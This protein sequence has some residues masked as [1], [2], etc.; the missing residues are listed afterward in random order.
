MWIRSPLWDGIWILSGA[1]LAAALLCLSTPQLYAILF[2]TVFADVGHSFS[3]VVLAWSHAGYREIMLARKRKYILLPLVIV[4]ATV[5]IGG[6]TTAGFLYYRPDVGFLKQMRGLD[7]TIN[8]PWL[9]VIWVYLV[10]NSYH[11]A[12]QNFGVL[13]LY[14]MRS[15]VGSRAVDKVFSFATTG[16]A[17]AIALPFSFIGWLNAR[18]SVFICTVTA[19]VAVLWMLWHDIGWGWC[20]PR[21]WLIA[22]D[23]AALALL[24]WNPLVGLAVYSVNHWLVS[25][26]LSGA[27]FT[28]QRGSLWGH[29]LNGCE[30]PI[31]MM[32]LGCLGFLF[33]WPIYLANGNV[34]VAV[35]TNP[36]VYSVR[37]AQGMLHLLYDRWV[38][39]LSD[40]RV[41]GIVAKDLL[42]VA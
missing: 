8:S 21:L 6:L 5:G 14:R 17:M 32:L 9:M 15:G 28:R 38:Y 26:G 23:G 10:W 18:Y 7:N 24:W 31:A 2:F 22:S 37:L 4:I 36:V 33:A 41:R 25:V 12:K 40:R 30:F 42:R 35:I 29:R 3:P 19:V 34:V 27:I 16:T 11:F 20:W 13:S 1:P 39:R